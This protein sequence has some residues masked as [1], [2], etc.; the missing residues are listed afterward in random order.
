MQHIDW[1]KSNAEVEVQIEEISHNMW[2]G[3]LVYSYWMIV[4]LNILNMLFQ[5]L[6]IAFPINQKHSLQ[7]FYSLK[8]EMRLLNEYWIHDQQHYLIFPALHL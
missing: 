1:L 7:I 6:A 4:I 2:D 5:A 3:N 8:V